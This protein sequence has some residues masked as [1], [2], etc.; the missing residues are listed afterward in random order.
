M[1]PFTHIQCVSAQYNRRHAT[2]FLSTEPTQDLDMHKLDIE[3]IRASMK[4]VKTI[5]KGSHHS[6]VASLL[7][8]HT[9]VYSGIAHFLQYGPLYRRIQECH[10]TT[11]AD[12]TVEALV[13]IKGRDDDLP[14]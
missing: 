13:K 5:G 8:S 3:S 2:G 1:L 4:P 7:N 11:R 10:T 9:E 12:G 6:H 14:K